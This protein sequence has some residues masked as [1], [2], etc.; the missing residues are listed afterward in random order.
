MKESIEHYISQLLFTEECVI[1]PEFG[2][3]IVNQQSAILNKKSGEIKAPSKRILFN[4]QLRNNDGLL[5]NYIAEEE[6]ISNKEALEKIINY[7]KEINN[8]LSGSR[9]LRIKNIGLFTLGKENNVL[10][11]QDESVNYDLNSFGFSSTYNK[12][13]LREN[14]INTQINSTIKSIEYQMRFPQA[15]LK[16]AVIIIP[17]IIIS[18]LGVQQEENITTV[19]EKMATMEIFSKKNEKIYSEKIAES[20]EIDKEILTPV[21]I[22]K[23]I[24]YYIIVGA[25]NEKNNAIRMQNK[26]GA[27]TRKS[28]ILKEGNLLRVSFDCYNTKEEALLVLKE[29]KKEHLS[30]W[31]LTKEL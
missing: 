4:N 27:K 12:S 30:A 2:G 6:K 17:L 20:P 15:M 16:A 3:F 7:S 11:T 9:I 23:K 28:E 21:T 19:Y 5:V 1:I 22:T 10:F 24:N 26:I 14:E 13:I 29:I 25:F 18:V 8:K 31:I